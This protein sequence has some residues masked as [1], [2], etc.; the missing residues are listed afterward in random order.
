MAAIDSAPAFSQPKVV[1]KAFLLPIVSDSYSYGLSTMSS[2]ASSLQISSLS[3]P[4]L[5]SSLASLPPFLSSLQAMGEERLP[6]MVTDKLNTARD[7]VT[8]GVQY[9]DSSLC[10][11]LDQLLVKVPSLTSPTPALYSSTREAAVSQ[12]AQATTYLA[13]FTLAQLA[14]K[15]SDSGL[16]T[17]ESFLK[18]APASY[19]SCCEPIV[20]GLKTVRS[21]VDRVRRDGARSNGSQKVASFESSSLLSAVSEVFGLNYVLDILGLTK[22]IAKAGAPGEVVKEDAPEMVEAAFEVVKEVVRAEAAA[23]FAVQKEGK[24][25][26]KSYKN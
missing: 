14:L 18:L 9:L 8:G 12:L 2:L 15:V 6:G 21:Q 26:K 1:E 5:T 7:Q 23:D 11:G 17:A 10:S 22:V 25:G 20:S 16:E 3:C 4:Y 13:S 19:S 24:R